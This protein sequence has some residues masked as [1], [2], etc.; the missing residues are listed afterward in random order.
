MAMPFGWS[1]GQTSNDPTL[2]VLKSL[3]DAYTILM[4]TSDNTPIALTIGE[5]TLIGRKTG[6]AIAA[7][8]GA[9]ALLAMGISATIAELN[10]VAG[11][12]SALQAQLNAKSPITS[13]TFTGTV[14]LPAVTLGGT[15]NAGATYLEI[16]S[17]GAGDSGGLLVKSTQGSNQGAFVHAWHESVSP[18]NDDFVGGLDVSGRDSNNVL[19]DFGGLYFMIEDVT[20]ATASGKLAIYLEQNTFFTSVLTLS[21]LGVLSIIGSYQVDGIQVVGNRVVDAGIDDVI[22]VG[23]TTLYP[24]ASAVL[25]ALQAG[26][27]THGLIKPT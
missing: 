16:D 27:Q 8:A 9:D 21:S 19:R 7:L 12:T 18:A 25:A 20:T 11:V 2:S 22:E 13:P 1:T 15:F 17:T 4:A 6:G 14:T 26:V 5:Q 10:Y 3:Y 24:N 23:F